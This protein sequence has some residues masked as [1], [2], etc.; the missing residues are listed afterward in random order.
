MYDWLDSLRLRLDGVDED[1][2][3]LWRVKVASDGSW[4][5]LTHYSCFS[6]EN[7][8]PNIAVMYNVLKPLP[9]QIQ[10]RLEVPRRALIYLLAHTQGV[11]MVE[12]FHH[13]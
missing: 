7:P 5:E 4:S 13:D 8:K 1:S 2:F 3:V 9:S 6:A 10:H 12:P 11:Y